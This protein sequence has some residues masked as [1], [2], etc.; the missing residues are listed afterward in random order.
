MPFDE[1]LEEDGSHYLA[2]ALMFSRVIQHRSRIKST[3]SL[4]I[5]QI[6]A[7]SDVG[8]KYLLLEKDINIYFYLKVKPLW[9]LSQ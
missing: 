8:S 2:L 3:T 4:I 1:M 5:N 7:S 6:L 9:L